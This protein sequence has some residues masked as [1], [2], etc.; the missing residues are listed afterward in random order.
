MRPL[1]GQDRKQLRSMAQHLKPLVFVGK[2]G[3]IETVISGTD[4]AL[5]A[6]ELIKVRFIDHKDEKKVLIEELAQATNSECVGMIGHVGVLY[7][8]Q[9]KEDKRK[10]DIPTP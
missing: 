1:N 3:I 4:Q 9:H 7:R 8:Y 10:I 6:H 5:E 2:Q